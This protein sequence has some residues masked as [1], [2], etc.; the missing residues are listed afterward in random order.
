MAAAVEKTAHTIRELGFVRRY[1]FSTDH[2]IVGLQFFF[3]AF[4]MA[5]VGAVLSILMRLQLAWPSQAWPLLGQL[6]PAGMEGGIMKPEFYLSLQTMHGT[7]MAIFVLTALFTGA[8][9]NYL[10]P[11][12]IGA[13]DM[14]FP[15]LNMLSFWLYLLS[16]L[17]VL[18]AF[19]VEGGAPISGWTA[20]PPLSALPGAGPGQSLGQ[21]IWIVAVALFIVYSFMGVL[22]YITTILQ[23]RTKG[24]S[25]TRLP[26][27][28]WGMLSGSIISL[29]AMPVL[30]AAGVLLLADRLIGTS[31]FVPAGLVLG[32]KV[33][34]HGGGHPLLWQHLFWFFGH[35]EV[36]IVIV[37]AMGIAAEI[38]ATFIRKPVFGYRVI[39]ICWL[40]ITAL[41]FLVW[42]HHMF[43]SGMNP[44]AGSVFAVLT[45]LITVPSSVLV[46]CWIAS[47]FG[48]RIHFTAPMLFAL[49]FVSVFV[50]GGLGGFFLG[51][52]WTDIQLHDTYFVVGHFHFTMAMSPLF[53][54]F[55]GIYYWFPRFFGRMMNEKLGKIHFWFTIAGSYLVFLTMHILGVGGMIR[56]TYD[57]TQYD[58]M[59]YMQP[60]NV[61]ITYCAFALA[62]SQ[63]IFV[64]NFAWSLFK[65]PQAEANPWKANT[66]EW[67]A[68]TP[69]PHGNWGDTVPAVH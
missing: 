55:A 6:L 8:F 42:G 9:G 67:Q 54:A 25:M 45:L 63:L 48:A 24:M 10:I 56:H 61:F 29:L 37:P 11:L 64:F 16:C 5:M 35:P 2:K 30:L 60:L 19:F 46:L 33:V 26:L 18:L 38:I 66:L 28:I 34:E 1:V 17:V 69:I 40:V 57:P 65:G 32:E 44:F 12:Q 13:R 41:S 15:F 39:V 49:G 20:Y 27:N 52:A 21:T 3:V 43:V 58:V 51:S 50:S 68:S 7:I 23:M 31:F 47:L 4:G 36:Y 59:R 53:A 14:A 62:A 22:N